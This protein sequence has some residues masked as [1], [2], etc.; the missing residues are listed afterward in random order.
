MQDELCTHCQLECTFTLCRTQAYSV[1]TLTDVAFNLA[2]HLHVTQLMTLLVC[3]DPRKGLINSIFYPPGSDPANGGEGSPGGGQ[4]TAATLNA[5]L[6]PSLLQYGPLTLLDV[7]VISALEPPSFQLLAAGAEEEELLK[8]Q[9]SGVSQDDRLRTAMFEKPYLLGATAQ[10]FD[11][12]FVGRKQR[13]LSPEE[14]R[15]LALRLLECLLQ[16]SP[17]LQ[18]A[19]SLLPAASAGAGGNALVPARKMSPLLR[20][21]KANDRAVV[22]MLLDHG[23]PVTDTDADGNTA[24]H[25]VI[26]QV[27][28][29]S[30]HAGEANAACSPSARPL[31]EGTTEWVSIWWIAW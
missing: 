20:A 4:G 8:A 31:Q 19:F 26:R 6:P 13:E 27:R 30:T 2:A 23:A 22:G 21:A 1:E 9:H 12:P 11:G 17:G 3:T 18:G 25:L 14:V 10:M 5:F 24:L 7:A 16:F 29:G 28:P 15:A